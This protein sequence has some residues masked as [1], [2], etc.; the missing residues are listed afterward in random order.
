MRRL[1]LDV[2]TRVARMSLK[3]TRRASRIALLTSGTRQEAVRSLI[4]L[5]EL[6]RSAMRTAMKLGTLIVA[7]S[8][9]PLGAE[10]GKVEGVGIAAG[11]GAVVAW[12]VGPVVGGV[13]GYTVVGPNIGSRAG[14]RPCWRDDRGSRHCARH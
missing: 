4:N 1:T 8:A 9:A 13:V 6:K 7:L 2:A 10:A 12:P 3:Q 14:N 5:I 11:A